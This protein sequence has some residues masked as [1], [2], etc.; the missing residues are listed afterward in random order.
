LVL[1]YVFFVKLLFIS[2]NGTKLF[3]YLGVSGF[4]RY[5]QI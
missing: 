1:T 2:G 5:I 3:I 4:Y